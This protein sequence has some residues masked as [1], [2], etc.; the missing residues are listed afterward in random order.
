[1]RLGRLP[2]GLPIG[3]AGRAGAA[4]R[5]C[6]AHRGCFGTC[7]GDRH[8]TEA[9]QTSQWHSRPPFQVGDIAPFANAWGTA[10]FALAR[11]RRANDWRPFRSRRAATSTGLSRRRAESAAYRR[12]FSDS[13]SAAH[14]ILCLA[15]TQADVRVQMP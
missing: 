5:R 10:P 8:P 14:A 11:T 4:R 3:N 9:P 13:G 15:D 1:V 7:A 12:R 6:S 2:R